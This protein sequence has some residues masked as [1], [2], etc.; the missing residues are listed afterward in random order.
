MH[1]VAFLGS[2]GVGKTTL[3]LS[4]LANAF[5]R[6]RRETIGVDIFAWNDLQL[7]DTAGCAEFEA[8]EEVTTRNAAIIVLA[9]ADAASFVEVQTRWYPRAC[10]ERDKVESAGFTRSRLVL[11]SMQSDKY[12]GDEENL[13][14]M[15]EAYAHSIGAEYTSVTAT[16]HASR[17]AF[18][19]LL[20]WLVGEKSNLPTTLADETAWK[21]QG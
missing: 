2:S 3:M 16:T 21:R 6:A 15:H 5:R 12:G 19:R 17:R 1:R 13:D 20:E 8:I 9:Y 14:V 18:F 7:W 11:V 10:R 4:H